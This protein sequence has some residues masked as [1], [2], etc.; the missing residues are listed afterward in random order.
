[1]NTTPKGPNGTDESPRKPLS[2]GSEFAGVGLQVGAVLLGGAWLGNWLDGKL[3]TLPW[4]T[5]LFVFLGA[6]AAFYN[7]Y[8][9][10]IGGARK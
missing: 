4:L 7:I 3:G 5:I 6:G 10:V 2:S 8:R 9:K 1:M